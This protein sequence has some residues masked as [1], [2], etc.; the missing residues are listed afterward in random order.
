VLSIAL[1]CSATSTA[2][3]WLAALSRH[4][5]AAAFD[6][7]DVIGPPPGGFDLRRFRQRADRMPG[8][9]GAQVTWT[10]AERQTVR[11]DLE[12]TYANAGR[13][14]RS[15]CRCSAGG[16][17]TCRSTATISSRPRPTT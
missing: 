7:L 17:A 4:D 11:V 9:R 13:A 12:G 8:L 16:S 15:R 5:D 6:R 1:G 2:D 10:E 14:C 3:A